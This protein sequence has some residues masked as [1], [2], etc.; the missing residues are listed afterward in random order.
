MNLGKCVEYN[1]K[2]T[3][4][5]GYYF[6]NLITPIISC[7]STTFRPY[8]TLERRIIHLPFTQNLPMER[9]YLQKFYN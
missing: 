1:C 5:I 9:F 4:L 6:E 7:Y 8:S 2:T 3:S